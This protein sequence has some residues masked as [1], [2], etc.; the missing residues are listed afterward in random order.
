MKYDA[1]LLRYDRQKVILIWYEI[2]KCF[3]FKPGLEI[4]LCNCGTQSANETGRAN[5][6][7]YI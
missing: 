1:N 6:P 3:F 5:L 4:W 2:Q 7:K